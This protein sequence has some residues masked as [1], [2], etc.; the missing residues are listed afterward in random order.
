MIRI[1]SLTKKYTIYA[2]KTDIL[3]ELFHPLRRVYHREFWALDG[4]NCTIG[5]GETVGI[6]GK[7]GAGK[8]T[9]L[10]IIT[11]VLTP[12]SGKV[13]TEGNISSLLE[14]GAGFNPEYTGIENIYLHGVITGVSHEEMSA[15]IPAIL[16]FADIGDFIHQ[17][18]KH[19]SSGMYARLAF[20]VAITVDPD[21]L[22]VDEALSVGD[23]RFQQKCYRKFAE[24]QNAGKT[25]LFVTH[26][27]IMIK[28][29]CTRALWVSDGKIVEDGTPEDVCKHYIAHMSYDAERIS[30]P[31]H[32][33]D[34]FEPA[35]KSSIP[36]ISTH[37]AESF[38]DR[39]AEITT[40]ALYNRNSGES[41]A[42][43]R[44][45]DWIVIEASVETHQRI[46]SPGIGVIFKDRVGNQIFGIGNYIYNIHFDDMCENSSYLIRI[47]FKLPPLQNG[48]YSVTI[49]L[50]EGTQE[51]HI[52][53]HWVHDI[54]SLRVENE[55]I[56]FRIGNQIILDP[57]S[58]ILKSEQTDG[59]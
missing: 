53:H 9:L 8:S 46:T 27:I 49:A 20:A 5:H 15:K 2:H 52:Q 38:G 31:T 51:N 25:I 36:R 24:L 39:G 10:K 45:G 6:L 33:S 34:G 18:V 59:E 41:H 11:G 21:I 29:Y 14:L 54:T 30:S 35:K 19:Y 42:I 17:K 22:I 23:M 26:D 13:I 37:A 58:V 48:E 47:E 55:A 28:N 50:S 12:T 56:A 16:E 44:Y 7:N 4:I 40:V 32:G 3:K 57:E 1:E 43:Y